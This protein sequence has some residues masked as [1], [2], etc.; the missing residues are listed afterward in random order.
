MVGDLALELKTAEE[1]RE[2]R[3]EKNANEQWW[4]RARS[5]DSSTVHKGYL[6]DAYK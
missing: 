4:T 6:C 5:P 3:H 1:I 2:D